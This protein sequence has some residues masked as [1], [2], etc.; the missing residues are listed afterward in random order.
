MACVNS[1]TLSL[2]LSPQL[3]E[4][5]KHIYEEYLSLAAPHTINIDDGTLKSIEANISNPTQQLFNEAQ[6]EVIRKLNF[7][8]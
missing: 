7:N 2:S 1:L 6:K 4:A 5:A 3:Q 8:D